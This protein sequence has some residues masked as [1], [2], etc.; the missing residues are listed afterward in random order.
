[1]ELQIAILSAVNDGKVDILIPYT[2]PDPLESQNLRQ[3]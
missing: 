3:A 1:M 2:D